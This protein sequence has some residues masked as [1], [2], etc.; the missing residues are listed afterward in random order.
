VLADRL[1]LLRALRGASPP[2][3]T[4]LA[5]VLV[6]GA[7]VPGAMAIVLGW[8]VGR[9]QGA[10]DPARAALLPVLALGGV[11]LAGHAAGALAKPLEFAARARIDG[12]HRRD[13]L[14]LTTGT[15]E[16]APLEDPEV[17]GLI[18]R[19]GAEP[20]YG[21][22]QPGRRCAHAAFQNQ[23]RRYLATAV[24]NKASTVQ[25]PPPRGASN[26]RR[27]ECSSWEPKTRRSSASSSAGGSSRCVPWRT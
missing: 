1:T 24:Q 3:V 25:P 19:A 13:I 22:D 10:A 20:D 21:V 27:R 12:A 15:R 11:V 23:I 2:V 6:A 7:C 16:I 9:F 17:R 14:R 8:A 26:R 5:V 18:R 4:G